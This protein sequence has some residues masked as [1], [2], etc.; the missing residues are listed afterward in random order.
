MISFSAADGSSI[1]LFRLTQNSQGDLAAIGRYEGSRN[2]SFPGDSANYPLSSYTTLDLSAA[3]NRDTW[4][5]RLFVRN[6]TN[7]YTYTFVIPPGGPEAPSSNVIL[8]PR[9][10]GL[11]VDVRF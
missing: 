2:T 1:F 8:Q 6:V 3:V 7:K 9:T 5:A 4:S 11:S 10:Y